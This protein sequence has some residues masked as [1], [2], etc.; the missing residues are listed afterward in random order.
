MRYRIISTETW[1]DAPGN[2]WFFNLPAD[3]KC[4]Y[5]FLFSNKFTHVSGL[6]PCSFVQI[7]ERF[8]GLSARKLRKILS[9]FTHA[10]KILYDERYGLMFI[11]NLLKYQT[12]EPSESIRKAVKAQFSLYRKHPF[13]LELS[14]RY[15]TYF[16]EKKEAPF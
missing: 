12:K 2:E 6:Y 10:G 14:Q 5:V 13:A 1:E 3:A 4:V 16:Q 15:P 8:P 9:D 7:L 11:L